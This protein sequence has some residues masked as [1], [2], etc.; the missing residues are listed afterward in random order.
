MANGD[1]PTAD[2][3]EPRSTVPIVVLV[4]ALLFALVIGRWMT[5]SFD[6]WV[7]LNPPEVL[8]TGIVEADLPDAARF[9]CSAP[10]GAEPAA[11]ASAQAEEALELQTLSRTPCDDSRTQHR[12]VGALDL[13]VILSASIATIVIWRRSR[14]RVD[15]SSSMTATAR[16]PQVG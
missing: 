2:Q 6:D 12:V 9:E 15:R 5:T 16:A 8:P 13:V 10:V 3:S 7:P 11:R 4:G 1:E 14:T